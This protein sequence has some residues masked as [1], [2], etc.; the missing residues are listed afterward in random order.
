M[1]EEII[2]RCSKFLYTAFQQS[3]IKFMISSFQK[4]VVSSS[5]TCFFAG[6][7]EKKLGNVDTSVINSNFLRFVLTKYR[8][9]K[10]DLL[11]IVKN[12]G[13]GLSLQGLKIGFYFSPVQIGSITLIATILTF[14]FLSMLF[15]RELSAAG[16]T[17]IIVFLLLSAKGLFCHTGWQEL[18][19]GSLFVKI[20]NYH[21]KNNR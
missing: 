21:S 9:I 6:I 4:I 16:L 20:L 7:A 5:K 11:N 10:D 8:I 3:K 17:M 13:I 14:L 1:I 12:S 19:T 15:G 2:K 18:K